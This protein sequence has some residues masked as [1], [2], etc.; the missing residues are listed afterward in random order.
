MNRSIVV[1]VLATGLKE[2]RRIGMKGWMESTADRVHAER[3]RCNSIG[4]E[5]LA[6][7]SRCEAIMAHRSALI[8][9]L[10]VASDHVL[11]VMIG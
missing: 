8:A 9:Q 4:I 7:T 1:V 11:P 10:D 3:I 5:I 2:G 6:N